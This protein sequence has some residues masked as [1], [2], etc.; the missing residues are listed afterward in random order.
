MYYYFIDYYMN[1]HKYYQKYI[2]IINHI[3]YIYIFLLIHILVVILLYHIMFIIYIYFYNYLN[4]KLYVNHLSFHNLLHNIN[5]NNKQPFN[6]MIDYTNQHIKIFLMYIMNNIILQ[7]KYHL[8]HII[9]Y[10][11]LIQIQMYKQYHKY[12]LIM[13]QHT[14]HYNLIH[15]SFLINNIYFLSIKLHIHLIIQFTYNFKLYLDMMKY[16]H[17]IYH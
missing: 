16:Q 7:N 9:Y 11:I 8:Q 12:F 5:L 15:I 14:L 1:Q 3:K 4:T 6:L 2:Y 13:E 10:F 17:I